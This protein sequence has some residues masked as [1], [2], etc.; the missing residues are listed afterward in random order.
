[1]WHGVVG[2][3]WVGFGKVTTLTILCGEARCDKV[4]YGGVRQGK[5]G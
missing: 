1:M 4:G 5:V 2:F 3:G